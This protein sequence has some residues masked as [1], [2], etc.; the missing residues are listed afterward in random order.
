MIFLAKY[1]FYLQ[2][3]M[4]KAKM[5]IALGLILRQLTGNL[6]VTKNGSKL[7]NL[8]LIFFKCQL[9]VEKFSRKLNYVAK[10]NFG[11]KTN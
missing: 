1:Q 6:L 10:Y 4:L 9:F 11:N 7:K 3:V 8:G 2:K 5:C